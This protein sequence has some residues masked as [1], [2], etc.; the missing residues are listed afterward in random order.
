MENDWNPDLYQAKHSFVWQL[1]QELV[2]LLNP[3]PGEFILDLGCGTGELTAAIASSGAR[4]MGLDADPAMIT[5][6]R[7]QFPH[8]HFEV[9]DARHFS[10]SAPVHGIFSNAVFH[11]IGEP[12]AVAAR[13]GAA[14]QPGGRLVAEFGGQGNMATVLQAIATAR[15]ALGYGPAPA[16]PWYFPALGEYASLLEAQGF[17]VQFARLYDRPTP[18]TGATG[19]SDWLQMFAGRYWA[20]LPPEHQPQLWQQIEQVAR[21]HLWRSGQWWADYRR[22]QVYAQKPD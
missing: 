1:S 9:A 7:Q 6:A 3:Q 12:A 22:L 4:V 8:L 5:T 19:L 10:L 11:W 16:T 18:L 2:E 17:E 15:D 21:P 14:L 20:D 13:M